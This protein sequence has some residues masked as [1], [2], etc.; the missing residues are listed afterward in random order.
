MSQTCYNIRIFAT[1]SVVTLSANFETYQSLFCYIIGKLGVTLS[2]DVTLWGVV[3]LSG[4]AGHLDFWWGD[5]R[6]TWLLKP[7]Y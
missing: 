2:V 6:K 5:S 1:L 7:F 3:A 4:V